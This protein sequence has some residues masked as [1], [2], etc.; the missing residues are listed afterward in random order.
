MLSVR[1]S[2]FLLGNVQIILVSRLKVLSKVN[3]TA[4]EL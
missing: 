1:C 3:T 2:P 4:I